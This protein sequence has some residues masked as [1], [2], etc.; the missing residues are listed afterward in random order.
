MNVLVFLIPVSLI[1]GGIGL[2]AFLWSL[3]NDQYEDLEGDA[4]RILSE[5]DDAP[6]PRD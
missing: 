6:T 3:R 1:L 2:A 5:D 4:W